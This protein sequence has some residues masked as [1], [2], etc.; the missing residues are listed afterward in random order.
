MGF[1]EPA[2]LELLDV[3]LHVLGDGERARLRAGRDAGAVARGAA[4]ADVA[5]LPAHVRVVEREAVRPRLAVGVAAVVVA[6]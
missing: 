4:R 6:A 2:Q 1:V 5:Q 3:T